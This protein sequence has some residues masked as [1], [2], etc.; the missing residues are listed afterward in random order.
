MLLI[1]MV[2]WAIFK[3]N[4]F[5]LNLNL[6]IEIQKEICYAYLLVKL[7]SHFMNDM[8]NTKKNTI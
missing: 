5:L 4:F 7:I 8:Y 2:I 6:L 1:L 3:L